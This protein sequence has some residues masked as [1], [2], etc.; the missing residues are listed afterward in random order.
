M[1]LDD[2]T[3]SELL[4]SLGAKTPTP[5]G[6]AVAPIAAGLG[7]ALAQMVVRFSQGRKRLA[8]HD[9]LH[10]EAID[11]LQR[12]IERMLALASEDAEAYA[13]LNALWKLEKGDPRRE[14]EWADALAGAIDAPRRVMESCLELLTLLERLCGKTSRTLNSDLAIAA[15]LAEAAA[16]AAAWNVRI[17]LPLLV[18]EEQAGVL[19]HETASG[20]ERA[21]TLCR[22]VE[23]ECRPA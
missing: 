18:D 5:G 3:V 21:R 15:V 9:P 17:N 16:R 22:A 8:E 7:A 14:A 4:T 11:E 2:L 20:V 12:I 6:G 10:V 13:R 1:G 19:E 23:G